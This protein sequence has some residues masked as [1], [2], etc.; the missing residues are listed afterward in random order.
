MGDTTVTCS[1]TDSHSNTASA[2]FKVTVVDTT[3]PILTIT[4]ATINGNPM[5]GT[6]LTGYILDTDNNPETEYLIQFKSDTTANEAL[7]NIYFGLKLTDS[8]RTAEELKAYYATH[9]EAPSLGD[10]N[11]AADGLGPFVYIT[12]EQYK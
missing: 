9:K 5:P 2:S 11:D 8:T 6:L 4:G 10:L 7:Q 12:E 1:V 3:A